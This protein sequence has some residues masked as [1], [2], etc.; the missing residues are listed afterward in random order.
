MLNRIV[1]MGR[2]TKDPELRKT[3]SGLSVTSLTL[4]VDRDF[5]DDDDGDLPF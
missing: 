4:A 1:L 2:L 3:Q 5:K